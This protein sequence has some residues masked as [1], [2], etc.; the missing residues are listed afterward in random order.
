MYKA[1]F[2]AER[3]SG[4]GGVDCRRACRMVH[5]VMAFVPQNDGFSS[6]ELSTVAAVT[7]EADGNG[8]PLLICAGFAWQRGRP[9][10]DGICR[11]GYLP[12]F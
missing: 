7:L 6:T 8:I 11:S 2:E 10:P 5:D 9:K 12:D 1:R 4:P 3:G